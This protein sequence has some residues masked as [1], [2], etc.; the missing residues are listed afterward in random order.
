[1][2]LDM[3]L[4]IIDVNSISKEEPFTKEE[5]FDLAKH[6]SLYRKSNQ[7]DLFA[8][9]DVKDWLNNKDVANLTEAETS[10]LIELF[11]A[12]EAINNFS[13]YWGPHHLLRGLLNYEES[14]IEKLH[15]YLRSYAEHMQQVS[16]IENF[17][18]KFNRYTQLCEF[19]YGNEINHYYW[20]K[21]NALH[22]WFVKHAQNGEDE[23]MYHPVDLETLKELRGTL[24]TIDALARN[25]HDAEEPSEQ[26]KEIASSL[27]PTG[28]GFLFGSTNYDKWYFEDAKKALKSIS[29]AIKLIEEND[30][31]IAIYRSSW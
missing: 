16:Q 26:S 1:M 3:Y 19:T 21:F 27:L 11:R 22:L 31:Y 7:F 8:I 29:Y 30:S 5:I 4:S 15:D 18:K 17:D 24:E 23:C 28:S 10:E 13:Y 6:I 14:K 20:R 9:P 25:E 2:G 12:N